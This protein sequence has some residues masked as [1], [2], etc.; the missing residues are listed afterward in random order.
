MSASATVPVG[1][2]LAV[3]GCPT[4]TIVSLDSFSGPDFLEV[5]DGTG[6]I[7]DFSTKSD[8]TPIVNKGAVV[9]VESTSE[10]TTRL[11]LMTPKPVLITITT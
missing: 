2:A 3:H 7:N 5:V 1:A 6:N 10:G 8:G 11:M 4:G 9:E